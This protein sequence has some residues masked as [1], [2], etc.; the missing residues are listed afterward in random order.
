MTVCAGYLGLLAGNR[1]RPLTRMEYHPLDTSS[2]Y[3]S[4]YIE[5]IYMGLQSKIQNMHNLGVTIKDNRS[6]MDYLKNKTVILPYLFDMVCE[7]KDSLDSPQVILEYSGPEYPYLFF[8]IRMDEY[9][10]DVLD[11]IDNIYDKYKN[12]IWDGQG[13]VIIMTDFQPPESETNRSS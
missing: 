3:K 7:L 2:P 10:D 6:I 12:A 11:V 13:N 4:H 5:S 8:L 9:P 1:V